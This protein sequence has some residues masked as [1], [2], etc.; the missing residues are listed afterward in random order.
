MIFMTYHIYILHIKSTD[1]EENVSTVV[2]QF[3]VKW[4]DLISQP[5]DEGIIG[6]ELSFSKKVKEKLR[7]EGEGGRWGEREERE[8]E[9]GAMEGGR[10]GERERGREG[11]RERG[12]EGERER[13]RGREGERE[14]GR[15]GE[16]EGGREGGRERGREGEREEEEK[17]DRIMGFHQ[18]R[19]GE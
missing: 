9:R 1:K 19:E 2:F 16:R 7:M 5:V 12:R 13:E 10:E 4:T 17:V 15:E 6:K 18:R 11:G 3:F 14:R 8:V